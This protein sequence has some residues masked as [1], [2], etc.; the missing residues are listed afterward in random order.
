MIRAICLS[1]IAILGTPCPATLLV[2]ACAAEHQPVMPAGTKIDGRVVSLAGPVEGALV[3]VKGWQERVAT[4]IEGRFVLPATQPFPSRLT[5][6]MEGYFVSGVDWPGGGNVTIKLRAHP[7][8]DCTDYQ[9]VDPRPGAA[10]SEQCGNCHE[11]IFREWS[12]SAHA[13]SATNRRFMNLYQG[14]DWHGNK[15]VGWNLLEE[16]PEA[17]GVCYS[18]HVP[19]LPPDPTVIRDLRNVTGVDRQ[20]IH[21][22][23]CHKIVDVS[24][25]NVGYDHGRF[26]MRHVRPTPGRQLFFGSLDDDRGRSVSLPLYRESRYC[27]SC[28]EGVVFGTHA[29]SEYSEWLASPYARKGVQCQDCHMASTGRMTNV[30]PGRG[31]VDRDPQTLSSHASSRGNPNALRSHLS[32]ALEGKTLA[33]GIEVSAEVRVEGVGHRTPTGYPSRAVILWIRA[34]TDEGRAVRLL[35]GPVLPPLAGEGPVADGGLA[36]QPGRIYA[37]VLEGLD[38]EVPVP[39]WKVNRL[40]YDTRL[41]P[42]QVDRARFLFARPPGNV[43]VV[44]QLIYRRFSKHLADQKKWPDNQ[45]VVTTK[46]WATP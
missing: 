21:C 41:M 37:K 15:N 46:R 7:Q 10:G 28:H 40:K 32:L 43:T 39:Y 17:S 27:A 34:T 9:W 45:F 36:G 22:D 42:D 19:S 6:S 33:E 26:A 29:Y 11:Q 5:A 24:I 25:D 3:G 23:F 13:R 38:G 31:G 8:E 18:C 44:G 1:S 16:Y 20:G 2:R 12:A 14:T 4:D 30:A 35:E